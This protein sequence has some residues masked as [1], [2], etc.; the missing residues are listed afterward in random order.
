MVSLSKFIFIVITTISIYIHIHFLYHMRYN[1]HNCKIITN[2][3]ETKQW[4][5][6]IDF[7]YTLI[8]FVYE[9][10]VYTLSDILEL[11]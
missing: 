6:K 3:Y 1:E 5:S 11:K 2:Y 7:C 8:D 9:S 4:I 10:N